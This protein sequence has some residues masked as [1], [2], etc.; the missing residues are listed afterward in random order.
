[1]SEI[2]HARVLKIAFPIVLANA[3]VPLLGLVDTGVVGQLGAAE[4]IGGVA[5]GA[6]VLSSIYWVCGFLRMGT[7]GLTSQA[8]GEGQSREVASL[9][10]RGLL[11]GGGFGLLVILLQLPLIAGAFAIS[12]ASD[13]VESLAREYMTI[14][15]WSAP[16]AVS[17]YAV[18]GWLIAQERSRA[19]LVQQI[20]ANGINIILDILFVL[21]WDFG[22]KGVA[23]ATFIAEWGGLLLG[24][25]LCRDAFAVKLRWP[26]ILDPAR[27]KRMAVVNTD[28]LIRTLLLQSII[29]LF[30]MWGARFGDV[31]LAANEVLMQFVTLTAFA[32]DGF[33]FSAEALV[34]QALGR[35][36][37]PMLRRAALLTSY[38]G[39]GACV[40]FAVFFAIGGGT[41][42]DILTTAPD[43]R[44]HAREFL[45]WMVAGPVIGVSAWMLDGIFIGATR[46]RDMRNMMLI[47]FVIYVAAA[48]PL[49]TAFGNHGLW[50]AML[51]SWIARGVTLGL[52][53]PALE[54]SAI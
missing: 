31:T 11:I 30:V 2:T 51:V 50:A 54:R 8:L 39:F 45:P 13:E 47:S 35:K 14:R 48:I 42:I 28:I 20:F 43:V 24:L 26:E 49:M 27:L 29:I 41:I 3:T 7:T 44:S 4:P 46:S 16:A 33:A 38:W 15:V 53:Y 36:D 21:V 17:M 37:K 34:G 5:I 23:M 40:V 12:P 22:V 1:M 18:T 25:W 10:L 32:L 19:V 52:R 6:L 9:L